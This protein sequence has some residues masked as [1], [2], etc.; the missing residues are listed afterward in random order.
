MALEPT[1]WAD[2]VEEDEEYKHTALSGR[3]MY[4]M[5]AEGARLAIPAPKGSAKKFV[6]HHF[7][8]YNIKGLQDI[9]DPQRTSKFLMTITRFFKNARGEITRDNISAFNR[10]AHGEKNTHTTF[11]I[12]GGKFATPALKITIALSKDPA[13][14]LETNETNA[15]YV[16]VV[17]PCGDITTAR[18]KQRAFLDNQFLFMDPNQ[19][20]IKDMSPDLQE[21]FRKPTDKHD[22]QFR[23][24]VF[25]MKWRSGGGVVL[26]NFNHPVVRNIL[27]TRGGGYDPEAFTNLTTL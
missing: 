17:L 1:S 19:Q 22:D 11:V 27:A 5:L 6:R 12:D 7:E 20:Y 16:C 2:E 10:G 3:G 4:G 26:R 9:P 8:E 18:G 23:E 21:Y 25:A 13:K 15:I 14:K 24:R